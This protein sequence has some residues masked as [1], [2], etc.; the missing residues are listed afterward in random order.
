MI[1]V[2]V[3]THEQPFNRLIKEVDI[4]KKNGLI[5]DEVIIQKG[6]SSYSPSYCNWKDFFSYEEMEYYI[7][8][9]EKIVTHGGPATFMKVISK[10]KIPIVVPRLLEHG[11]H[12]NNHQLEF[13]REVKKK[14]YGIEII[15]DIS[16]L[17]QILNTTSNTSNFKS[18]NKE[19]NNRLKK[20]IMEMFE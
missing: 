20:I 15:E 17:P 5:D 12:V 19:F 14:N 16:M 18:C 1:F 2:T 8:N 4:A 6:Y 11:E 10:G 7:D 13:A 9:A 3:G